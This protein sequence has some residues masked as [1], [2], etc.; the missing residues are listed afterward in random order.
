MAAGRDALALFS[1]VSD[2]GFGGQHQSRD[3]A[4]VGESRAH[5][6]RRIEHA[7][8]DQVFVVAGQRVVAEVVVLRVVNLSQ[9]D[10]AFFAGVLGDLAQRLYESTLHNV[11]ADLLIALDIQLVECGDA[12]DQDY[13]AARDDALFD[14]RTGCV[15]GVLDTSLLLFHFGFGCGPH[16]DYGYATDQFRQPLLQL[17]AVVVAGGLIDLAANFLHPAFDVGVLA[18]TFDDGGVVLVN[19]DLLGL[20]EILHLHVLELDA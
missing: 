16:F 1:N 6:L 3:G 4:G 11:D 15:H 20:S 7:R 8:L 18:F 10:G 13:T 14:R 5:D 17:L 9:H 19:G 12:A 2:E